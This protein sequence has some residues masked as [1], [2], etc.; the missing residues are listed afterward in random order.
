MLSEVIY[1]FIIFNNE[2]FFIITITEGMIIENLDSPIR[3]F[4]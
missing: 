2:L 4:L 1:K 3:V